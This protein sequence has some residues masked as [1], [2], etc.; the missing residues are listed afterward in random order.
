MVEPDFQIFRDA[1][2]LVCWGLGLWITI[3]C[4]A[5]ELVFSV[6]LTRATRTV[7]SLDLPRAARWK[8]IVDLTKW[9]FATFLFPT[10][11][12]LG[13]MLLGSGEPRLE[14]YGIVALPIMWLTGIVIIVLLVGKL[15]LELDTLRRSLAP[16]SRT[17]RRSCR[18]RWS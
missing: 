6:A 17:A 12:I 7:F 14:R 4:F 5:C 3:Y 15:V 2:A 18:G 10:G 11:H 16:T 9:G 1:F 13:P 8:E